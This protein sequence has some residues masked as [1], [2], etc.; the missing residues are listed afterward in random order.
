M[1]DDLHRRV[2]ALVA[3][4]HALRTSRSGDGLD[5]QDRT[6]LRELEERLD[7]TWDLLRQRQALREA[8]MDPAGAT[9]RR[10]DVVEGYTN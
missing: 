7:M 5:E 2:D 1:D 4:E 6:R 8:G 9:E 3:E 10:A